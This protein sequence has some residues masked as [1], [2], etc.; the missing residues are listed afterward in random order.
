[1]GQNFFKLSNTRNVFLIPGSHHLIKIYF[2]YYLKPVQDSKLSDTFMK[3]LS[4]VNAKN[5]QVYFEINNIRSLLREHKMKQ[6]FSISH[7]SKNSFI[8]CCQ[9][10]QFKPSFWS[11]QSR[12]QHNAG[13]IA[14]FLKYIIY[15]GNQNTYFVLLV[16]KH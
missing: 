11:R 13:T 6:S 9:N 15:I 8:R 12:K 5:F 2:Y 4:F 16:I 10:G 14:I 1:M 7:K 3:F